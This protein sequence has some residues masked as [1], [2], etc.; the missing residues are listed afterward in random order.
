MLFK[1]L[2]ITFQDFWVIMNYK[3]FIFWTLTIRYLHES[4]SRYSQIGKLQV[5][6]VSL[7]EACYSD[8]RPNFLKK[9]QVFVVVC[10]CRMVEIFDKFVHHYFWI[11]WKQKSLKIYRK[12]DFLNK[13]KLG[14]EWKQTILI[15]LVAFYS[16]C[17]CNQGCHWWGKSQGNLVSGKSEGILRLVRK[18]WNFVESQVNLRKVRE[19]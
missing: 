18:M 9:L 16:K 6:F 13:R 2:C 7:I 12:A 3:L 4:L 17:F 15:I 19:I 14:P 10:Q 1:M 11:H 5:S 8:M